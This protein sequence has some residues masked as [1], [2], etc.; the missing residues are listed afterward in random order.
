MIPG[1]LFKHSK[2]LASF[3]SI[4]SANRYPNGAILF[5]AGLG[6]GLLCPG[7]TL[8]MSSHFRV[9][10]PVLSSS[11]NR[12]GTSTLNKDA[13]ELLEVIKCVKE[14]MPDIQQIVLMGFSTGCQSI[15]T[16]LASFK[17]QLPSQFIKGI[18]LQGA[19]SDRQYFLCESNPES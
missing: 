12:F 15:C 3:I 13:E 14:N 17:G 6:D 1:G 4:P 7:Y 10:Q 18:V 2:Q 11:Y 5:V 16:L 8:T 9:I 19:V